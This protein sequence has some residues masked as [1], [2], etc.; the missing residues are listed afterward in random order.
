MTTEAPTAANP[1]AFTFVGGPEGAMR[2]VS[3]ATFSGAPI[4][5]VA[6]VG[7]FPGLLAEVPANAAWALCGV[8]SNDRYTTRSEK[9]ELAS[10]QA[11]IGRPEATKAALILLR[12][13]AEW[14]ALT[15]DE[16]RAI[17]EEDSHHIAIG[18]RYLPAVARRLLH[19]RDLATEAPFDFIGFLDFASGDEPAFDEMMGEL[20]ATKEWSFMDREVDIRLTKN[21]R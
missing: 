21:D 4:A 19:C 20:R 11:P 2:V 17:L 15:Q 10:R 14:W 3:Q 9:A 13:R 5:P 7:M 1:R 6:R 18:M 8:A 16:R 12:K